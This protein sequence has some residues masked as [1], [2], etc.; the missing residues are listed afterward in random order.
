VNPLSA[1]EGRVLR[2]RLR[3]LIKEHSQ[4]LRNLTVAY[5][6]SLESAAAELPKLRAEALKSREK[7]D[8]ETR[9]QFESS[10]AKSGAGY[11]LK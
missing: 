5:R 2:E 1:Q 8:F 7:A 10:V 11:F 9:E 3:S 6:S 4:A